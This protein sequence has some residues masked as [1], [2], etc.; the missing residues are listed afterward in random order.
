[1]QVQTSTAVRKKKIYNSRYMWY[2]KH[3]P[4][5]GYARTTV[6]DIDG[7]EKV[8]LK[9]LITIAQYVA[10]WGNIEVN[11]HALDVNGDGVVNLKDLVLLSQYVAGWD[12][13]I[14]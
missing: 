4:Q 14:S 8:N 2:I 3:I 6:G 10:E 5:C 9:D 11:E 1:M 13:E 7:D 12:V